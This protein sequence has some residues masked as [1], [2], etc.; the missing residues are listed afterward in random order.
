MAAVLCQSLLL[1]GGATSAIA[2]HVAA[3][4]H[5]GQGFSWWA[6]L[7]PLLAYGL[8]PLPLLLGVAARRAHD[9]VFDDESSAYGAQHWA[10]FSGSLLLT[11]VLGLPLVLSHSGVLDTAD[12]ALTLGG[13]ALAALTVGVGA[14][15]ARQ[16]DEDSWGGGV[17]LLSS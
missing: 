5:F 17:S 16:R 11:L 6:L 1:A 4:T 14:C 13:L 7:P 3:T 10:E 15:F 9:S 2:L 12:A 8:A